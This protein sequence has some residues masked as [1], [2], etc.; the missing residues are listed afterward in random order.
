MRKSGLPQGTWVVVADGEKALVLVNEGDEIDM[1]LSLRRKDEQENP[2]AQD[3]AANRPGRFNDGPTVHRSAVQDTDWHELEKERFASDLAE[4]LYSAAHDGKF[5]K[6]A[7]VA[8]RVV[9]SQLREEMHKEVVDR[10][11]LE[12]PKVLTNHPID[13]IEKHLAQDLAEAS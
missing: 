11:I 8:S 9:L 12:V 1:K 5:D 4:R 6:L 2:K 3:R 10:V 13:E 7:I